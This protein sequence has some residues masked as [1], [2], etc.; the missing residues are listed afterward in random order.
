MFAF[1]IASLQNSLQPAPYLQL[2]DPLLPV[3]GAEGC[4]ESFVVDGYVPRVEAC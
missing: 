1:A 4:A 2:S 3:E